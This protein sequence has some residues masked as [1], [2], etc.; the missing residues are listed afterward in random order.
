MNHSAVDADGVSGVLG[1]LAKIL[2]DVVEVV[3][4]ADMETEH[5]LNLVRR[6]RYDTTAYRRS[7][8]DV[9]YGGATWRMMFGGATVS[10][11][12][13]AHC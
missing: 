12:R 8:T 10:P 5:R 7:E 4:S 13:Y 1:V 11:S 3:R 6:A 9:A 2:N